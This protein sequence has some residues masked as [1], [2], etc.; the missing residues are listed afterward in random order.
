MLVSVGERNFEGAQS[1]FSVCIALHS[2]KFY[3]HLTSEKVFSEKSMS[4]MQ[5]ISNLLTSGQS[6]CK[7]V[8]SAAASL[9]PIFS[10]VSFSVVVS[11]CLCLHS[12]ELD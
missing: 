3:Y 2:L 9:Q 6:N 10:L 12:S 11:L 1:P 8:F 4:S 7:E 5:S